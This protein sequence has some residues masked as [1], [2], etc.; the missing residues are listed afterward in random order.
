MK[1]G[2]NQTAFTLDL[3][4][5]PSGGGSGVTYEAG[6]HVSI[7]SD[8]KI[9]VIADGAVEKNN[10]GLVTGGKV[11]DAIQTQIGQIAPYTGDNETIT[12]T[13]KKISAKTGTIGSGVKTLITGDTAYQA[14]VKNAIYS[15]NDDKKTITVKNGAD[16]T[17]FT[18]NLD[19][20]AG[21]SGVTYEAGDNISISSDN[22]ISVKTDGK[23]EKGN[24]G[25]V[26][27]GAIYEKVGDTAKLTEAGLGENLTDS[28]LNVNSRIGRLD[29]DISKAGAGA[30]ALAALR[31]EAFNPSD[32]ISFALGYG[33]YRGT[34]AGAF[35]AFYKPNADTTLSV[36][37][38]IG[39][40]DSMMN[41]GISFKLGSRG[42]SLG[43]YS[44]NAELVREVNALR[45]DN[46]LLKAD[47]ARMK[48]QIALI[49]A[50]MEMSGT[51]KKSVT[52]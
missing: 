28:V 37:A 48:Q 45:V 21:G 46:E 40:S 9:S 49:L 32:K 33:H 36:G 24:T 41:A 34:S 18:L 47:N 12:V 19:G 16:Q 39:N 3:S 10:T 20:L 1:N 5:L 13:D 31:P 35:G 25:I 6:D 43:V 8:N 29:S 15:L 51:V 22:V 7:S 30:A 27:G 44:S 17:A 52:R 42:Q 2:S 23:I 11:Y 4:G 38:T 26:T 14:L 50:N